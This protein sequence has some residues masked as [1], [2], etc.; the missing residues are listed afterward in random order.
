MQII[1][2]ATESHKA[3]RKIRGEDT[4]QPC[5]HQRFV[6]DLRDEQGRPTGKLRC[7]ECNAVFPD[8]DERPHPST[9]SEWNVPWSCRLFAASSSYYL[10][11][12]ASL[13]LDREKDRGLAAMHEQKR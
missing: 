8:P 13:R 10:Q 9:S 3:G 1:L 11:T 4:R 12:T 7:V 5:A 2:M 6:D